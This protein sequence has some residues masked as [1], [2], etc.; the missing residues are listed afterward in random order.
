LIPTGQFKKI[1]NFEKLKMEVLKGCLV[2]V[3][4]ALEELPSTLDRK[5]KKAPDKSLCIWFCFFNVIVFS[6]KNSQRFFLKCVTFI[7]I[8]VCTILLLQLFL[9]NK[10]AAHAKQAL[11]TKEVGNVSYRGSIRPLY[12]ILVPLCLQLSVVFPSLS[13]C[14][15]FSLC[16]FLFLCWQL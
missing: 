10:V 4:S 3:Y 7:G 15:F 1:E 6:S 11:A 8:T 2:N 16:V 14:A 9:Q 12:N 13:L 5:T